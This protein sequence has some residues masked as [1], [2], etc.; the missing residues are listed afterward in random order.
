MNANNAST[1]AAIEKQILHP[2]LQAALSSLNINLEE[3]LDCFRQEQKQ[4]QGIT[5]SSKEHSVSSPVPVSE[6]QSSLVAQT[7]ED[8]EADSPQ[9]YL[10]SSEELL[11]SLEES[12]EWGISSLTETTETKQTNVA[13]NPS[14][15]TSSWR[16]YLL[17]P[18][19]IAGILIFLLS[20]V[21]LSM[22]FINLGQSRLSTSS[23][24]S[25]VDQT[26]PPEEPTITSEEEEES[27]LS[28]IP[29]RP[30]L[31]ED[32]FIELDVDNLVEAEP[33]NEVPASAKPSCGG[34]FYCVMVENPD[35]TTYQKTRQ[36]VADAY[37]REF[38]TIGQ[39]LQVAAFDS[40]SRA[41]EL[42]QELAEQGVTAVI[43][44][45]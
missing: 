1:N 20:G 24:S 25:S 16:S 33:L 22:M 38:P 4:R 8:S 2:K 32:E 42:Q 19:G 9:N 18:L 28:G 5:L 30:D 12:E 43:Y 13:Q 11:R 31:A 21:L 26:L 41:E 17:T 6:F 36:L 27:G 39:V 45:P 23:S 15:S 44:N 34:N 7:E 14:T 35:Q 29:N 10:A 3:E 40:E 37:L